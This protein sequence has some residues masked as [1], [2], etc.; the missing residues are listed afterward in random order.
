[1]YLTE[2]NHTLDES[3]QASA[4]IEVTPEMIAAGVSA[5]MECE[6]VN[7]DFTLEECVPENEEVRRIFCAMY[8]AMLVGASH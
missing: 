3:G 2:Q 6:W 5:Y 1:M 4:E 7:A 8:S